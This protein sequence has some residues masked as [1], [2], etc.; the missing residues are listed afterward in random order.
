MIINFNPQTF[1]AKIINTGA[2]KKLKYYFD[3]QDDNHELCSCFDKFLVAL[4]CVLPNDSDEVIINK[5]ELK[6]N[7]DS[8]I[9]ISGT[10]SRKGHCRKFFVK[11]SVYKGAAHIHRNIV[12]AIRKTMRARHRSK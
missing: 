10:I 12:Q 4:D 7:P 2:T 3:C 6:S 5:V 8:N 11:S 1:N 9:E